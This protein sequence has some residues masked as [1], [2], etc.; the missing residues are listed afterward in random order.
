MNAN[1]QD[2]NLRCIFT[3]KSFTIPP[4]SLAAAFGFTDAVIRRI[5]NGFIPDSSRTVLTS[6]IFRKS[7][8]CFTPIAAALY[9]SIFSK[10]FSIVSVKF[11]PNKSTSPFLSVRSLNAGEV[12]A[13][14]IF[15]N[16]PPSI[17]AFP[18]FSAVIVLVGK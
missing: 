14:N 12:S 2:V 13:E 17:K 15:A 6:G 18:C 11:P 7:R 16:S 5:I 1:A 4:V 9:R 3:M 8:I 10:W